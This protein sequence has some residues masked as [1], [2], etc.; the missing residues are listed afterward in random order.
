[1]TRLAGS[2]SLRQTS[3]SVLGGVREDRIYFMHRT[4]D[5]PYKEGFGLGHS[6][7]PL[8]DSGVYNMRTGPNG[9]IKPLL[10]EAVMAELKGKRQFLI[11]FFPAD[12]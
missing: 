6:K 10:P 12:E 9:E 5:H 7:D 8:A 11:W 1:M 4:F 2:R 3:K